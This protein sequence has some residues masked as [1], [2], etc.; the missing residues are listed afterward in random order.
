[1]TKNANTSVLSP[2]AISLPAYVLADDYVEVIEALNYAAAQAVQS[3]DWSGKV[4]AYTTAQPTPLLEF[5][6]WI[7]SWSAQVDVF[8]TTAATGTASVTVTVGSAPPWT[9]PIGQQSIPL[10]TSNTGTGWRLVTVSANVSS[11]SLDLTLLHVATKPVDA[12]DLPSPVVE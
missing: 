6:V 1:M 7:P 10:L 8:L 3:F 9:P 4:R 11:G 5:W 12:G 2:D